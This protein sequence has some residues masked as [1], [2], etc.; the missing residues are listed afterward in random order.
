METSLSV[1][2]WIIRKWHVDTA[3]TTVTASVA[4]PEVKQSNWEVFRDTLSCK[5]VFLI[6]NIL[7]YCSQPDDITLAGPGSPSKDCTVLHVEKSQFVLNKRHFKVI[8]RSS[9]GLEFIRFWR[10]SGRNKSKEW[11][12]FSPLCCVMQPLE[13][14]HSPSFSLSD[15]I[16][17]C[18]T[19]WHSLSTSSVLKGLHPLTQDSLSL[20]SSIISCNVLNLES[21]NKSS[22][23]LY[24]CLF[25]CFSHFCVAEIANCSC[26]KMARPENPP[27]G[28]GF[29][30]SR[31]RLDSSVYRDCLM[32]EIFFK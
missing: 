9:L 29:Y 26:F 19:L 16:S 14:S 4:R 7:G 2:Q 31:I 6:W 1:S 28:N 13:L 3:A 25:L 15:S 10:D 22:A 12:L 18:L 27:D 24:L 20:S 8:K 21:P 30:S 11:V 32:K 5:L 23:S 17:H